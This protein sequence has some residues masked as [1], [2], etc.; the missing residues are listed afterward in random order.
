MK[1]VKDI[2][3]EKTEFGPGK[4]ALYY[5]NKGLFA[6]PFLEER[7]PN[8][9]KY[10]NHPSTKFLHNFWNIEESDN[11]QKYEQA[12]KAILDLWEELDQDIPKYCKK[13]RQLQNSW[14]DKV[15][16]ILGWEYEL[17]ESSQKHGVTNYPD[18]T[19]FATK[20]D[21]KKSKTSSSNLKFKSALAVADAKDWGVPL[22]GK[23][24]T[25]QNPSFQII[26]YLKQTDKQWGILT[27]G[28]YWRIYSL[29]SESKHTTYYEVDLEKIL[30]TKDYSRFKYFYNFFR[31][32]A[33][34][35]DSRL[36][37]R[38]FLDFVFEDG[39]FYSQR[40]ENNLQERVYKVVDSIC[41]GFL[42]TYKEPSEDDLK[43]VY[44]YSM[45]YLFKLMFVLNC[46]SKGLLEVNKQDDYYEFSLRKMCMDIKEQ[47]E[48]KKTWSGQPKTYNHI[49]DLFV[50]LKAGDSRIGVHGF[51]EEPFEIG[52]EE[53]YSKHKISD[54]FLN[55]AILEL[56][57][58]FDEED[59]LQFIDYK[60]LSSDHIGSLFE[61]LLE[62]NLIKKGRKVELLN[63]KGDRKATGSYYTPEYL[64]DYIVEE[65]VSPLIN[66]KDISEI[67]KLKILDPSM[68]SGH[69]LL[70]VV[71]FL[72]KKITEIQD[73]NEKV[74][75]AIEFD[76]IRKEVLKNCVFGIDIN[77]L[78]TQLAKFSL[79][80]YT[81]QKGDTLE[82]LAD[83]LVC[84]NALL[85]SLNY[86][87]VFNNQIR[88]GSIDAIVGNPP[89]IGEKGNK[90]I[91]Q[92]VKETGFGKAYYQGK[93]DYFYFFFHK[94]LDLLKD[95][96]RSGLV[97]TNYFGTALGAK[98]LRT[99][100]A[101]RSTIWKI[102]NFNNLKIFK[103]AQGQ[104]NQV[105]FFK[106]GSDSSISCE[107]FYALKTGPSNS[108]ILDSVLS[109]NKQD[110]VY[111]S[112]AQEELFE[113]DELYLR[114][115]SDSNEDSKD[116]LNKIATYNK[117]VGE[118]YRVNNGIH[119]NADYLSQK[120]FDE[121]NNKR[122]EVGDG[123]Y[124]LD[125]KNAE[126]KSVISQIKK[127]KEGSLLYPF[128]KNSD[129]SFFHTNE[130]TSKWIIYLNKNDDD[131]DNFPNTRK[132]LLD[133]KNIIEKSSDNYP[134]LHR[135]KTKSDFL[136]EKIVV[137]QRNRYNKFGYNESI[138]FAA[139]DVFFVTMQENSPYSLKTLLALLNSKAYFVWFYFKGKRKGETLELIKTPIA[140]APLPKLSGAQAERLAIFSEKLNQSYND[141][142]FD[143]LNKLVY[144]VFDFEEAQI[145]YIENFY[146]QKVVSLT[147]E[148]DLSEDEVA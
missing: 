120:K 100:L 39:K 79:W 69:F 89:Y 93:M 119:T 122:K 128:Y 146:E 57:C 44:E 102:V 11:A 61:G 25:N 52:S 53:F 10:Y 139:S 92:E 56:S 106:K 127:G 131:I 115:S 130:R 143:E 73:S 43:E 97:S 118:Y 126:D 48:A 109:K 67:T 140:E 83:Q 47:F 132:H 75:G 12:F 80:I 27:D 85:D 91:F 145:K 3:G 84:S 60:I 121:R 45:Y 19:L 136:S 40:V 135:P 14:I 30:A 34:I 18:Y 41:Q 38:T 37:D 105:T 2:V 113:G 86:K 16:K 117:V 90:E 51:G 21:W 142:T 50:L 95:K 9:E 125:E 63:T 104:H 66:K 20:E 103:G 33:F 108:K 96:G 15:F 35:N 70:G 137:S 8:L 144:S 65:V 46:E 112:I 36:N 81:S 64:V 58:D 42:E 55:K 133:F 94:T 74:K 7:L 49:N 59:N 31:V 107:L 6:D 114:I 32:E 129:I 77:P 1:A 111:S 134:Y 116:V 23:G 28:K 26:N 13:E 62:F 68:G 123:I 147:G 29:R 76:K 98:T 110:T 71:K 54:E 138:W 22:D 99:D 24:A 124:I 82:P 148:I 17:E 87:E 88:P 4:T 141:K 72:E 5:N 101:K 78:A